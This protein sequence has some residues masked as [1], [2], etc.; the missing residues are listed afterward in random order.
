ML[1]LGSGLELVFKQCS[2]C[3]E[4]HRCYA[5]GWPY[6]D[7]SSLFVD[8]LS[9]PPTFT[10]PAFTVFHLLWPSTAGHRAF[11]HWHPVQD[12]FPHADLHSSVRCGHR[13]IIW[14]AAVC[15]LCETMSKSLTKRRVGDGLDY[16][17][18]SNTQVLLEYSLL[19]ISGW[20]FP[21]P[22]AVFIQLRNC[23]N[24]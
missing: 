14:T 19:F 22:V 7:N 20:E 9:L 17:E 5:H 18:Y 6:D 8:L 13:L 11:H 2:L 4:C 10:I 12:I 3:R 15:A 1:G 16:R 21:L 23:W 24:L